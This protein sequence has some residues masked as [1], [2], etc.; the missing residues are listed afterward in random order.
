MNVLPNKIKNNSVSLTIFLKLT[1]KVVAFF[2]GPPCII[3]V[4]ELKIENKE[5]ISIWEVV[6]NCDH[7]I[8]PYVPEK[9]QSE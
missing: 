4:K 6:C 2:S 3:C 1:I 9:L 7:G 5:K 8:L